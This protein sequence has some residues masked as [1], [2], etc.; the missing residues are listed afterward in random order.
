MEKWKMRSVE[1]HDLNLAKVCLYGQ[2]YINIL[3]LHYLLLTH[4]SCALAENLESLVT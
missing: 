1:E 4:L 3:P 2:K